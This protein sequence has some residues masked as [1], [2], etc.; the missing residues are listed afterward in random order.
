MPSVPGRL[1]MRRTIGSGRAARGRE[2]RLQIAELGAR[3]EPAVPQQVAH[4]LEG[5]ARRELVDVV[6]AVGEDTLLP[7]EIADRR[8]RGDDI[9]EP[10]LRFLRGSHELNLTPRRQGPP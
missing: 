8:R 10:A 7:I 9:L 6:P 2:L 5:G 1:R 4:L 3:R